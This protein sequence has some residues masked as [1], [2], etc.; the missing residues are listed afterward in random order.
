MF[1]KDVGTSA[2]MW[3]AWYHLI[4]IHA[5]DEFDNGARAARE[6]PFDRN[7]EK[8]HWFFHDSVSARE[9]IF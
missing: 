8:K 5:T 7:V 2:R 4:G 9:R 3:P 6:G 1:W